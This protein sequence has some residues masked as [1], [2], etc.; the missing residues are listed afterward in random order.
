MK[1]IVWL[2]VLLGVALLAVGCGSHLA[3]PTHL[4][5]AGG[6]LSWDAVDGAVRYEVEINGRSQA[7]VEANS[8]AVSLTTSAV[9]RVRALGDVQGKA[10]SD[11]SAPYTYTPASA[12]LPS[13]ATPSIVDVNGQ[14]VLSWTTVVGATTY[15]IW[16]NNSALCEVQGATAYT[17]AWDADGTYRYQVQALGN[18]S[19]GDGE[20]SK[21][22]SVLVEGGSVVP[23]RLRSVELAFDSM[24]ASLY[25]RTVPNAVSYTVWQNDVATVVSAQAAYMVQGTPYCR[26][27]LVVDAAHTDVYVVANADPALYRNSD[28]SNTLSFPLEADPAPENL[29]CEVQEGGVYL[30]WT[31]VTHCLAYQVRVEQADGTR[32]V[33]ETALPRLRLQLA[34]GDYAASVRGVGNGMLYRDTQYSPQYALSLVDGALPA[35]RLE[36]PDGLALNQYTLQ[37][38]A[39]AHAGGYQI[40]L[41]TPY[42]EVAAQTYITVD[43]PTYTLPAALY[44]SIVYLSVRALG[45]DGYLASD[46]SAEVCYMPAFYYMDEHIK[47]QSCLPTPSLRL[48]DG[49][50]HW[51][52]IAGATGYE[53]VVNGLSIEGTALR[54]S[55]RDYSG[56]VVCKIRALSQDENIKN[57]PF[58]PELAVTMPV[59]LAT[60]TNLRISGGVLAWDEVMG[61]AGYVL[62][63]GDAT[64]NFSA[65][66]VDL[67]RVLDVDGIY[68]LR[69]AALSADPWQQRSLYSATVD[70]VVDYQTV[71]TEAKPHPIANAADWALLAQYPTQ[72]F[73]LQADITLDGGCLF[74]NDRPFGGVLEGNGHTLTVRVDTPCGFMGALYGAT[75]RNV[76]LQAEVSALTG[77]VAVLAAVAWGS[78]LQGVTLR[79]TAHSDG[80][81]ATVLDST[82]CTYRQCDFAVQ[83]T[84]AGVVAGLAAHAQGDTYDGVSLAGS[85][86]GS[87]NVG[88]LVADAV[89]VT[90]TDVTIGADAP[91]ALQC[92]HGNAGAVAQGSL[93]TAQATVDLSVTAAGVCNVGALGGSLSARSATGTYRLGATA[94]CEVL[95]V[96]GL[97][98]AGGVADADVQVTVVLR[99]SAQRGYLGGFVGFVNAAAACSD[100]SGV[101]MD[102]DLTM[103]QG[104]VGGAAGLGVCAYAGWPTGK[105]RVGADVTVAL[106]NRDEEPTPWDAWVV[107]RN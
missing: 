51:G 34:D 49:V 4:G 60:P 93:L 87:G 86:A 21:P 20:R 36:A 25:W 35:V 62:D 81:L 97:V 85:V 79:C 48:Q 84:A 15:R 54:Y 88:A 29:H 44:E 16:Q 43:S 8:Y 71:G 57:S 90:L 45:S 47:V 22:Y 5:Y 53:L 73:A 12:D 17:L 80:R 61:A 66:S 2:L 40:S 13:L 68:S 105:V 24:D 76:A 65:A 26:Y 39:V 82:D 19:Y 77:D 46:A 95:F 52:S 9:F 3:A 30:A 58:G 104:S 103:P 89:G 31:A 74:D 100:T 67:K 106:R 41:S 55:L 33:F 6:V 38:G 18:A 10:V 92:T 78:T 59:R 42:E 102:I 70:F 23:P 83:Y 32:Q 91:F 96:G 14:G 11:Y 56:R 94:D 99:G 69:V 50:L 27:A 101:D 63:A 75:I 7:V 28:A 64:Y 98:G 37:F 72:A 1:K 107:Q